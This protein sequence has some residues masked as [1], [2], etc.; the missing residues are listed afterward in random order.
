MA[1]KLKQIQRFV[2]ILDGLVSKSPLA[3]R[4]PTICELWLTQSIYLYVC[5]YGYMVV[6]VCIYVWLYGMNVF[7]VCLYVLYVSIYLTMYVCGVYEWM[8][9]YMYICTTCFHCVGIYPY[10]TKS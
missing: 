6:C 10:S 1:D 8:Y 2:E 5:M 4:S 7:H 3:S 9:V